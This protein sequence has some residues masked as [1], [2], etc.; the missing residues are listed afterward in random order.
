MKCFTGGGP[1]VALMAS[2]NVDCLPCTETDCVDINAISCTN[3]T[4][5]LQPDFSVSATSILQEAALDDMTGQRSVYRCAVSG[6][7]LGDAD[8]GVQTTSGPQCA[9]PYDGPLC[10]YCASG[11]SRPGFTGECNECSGSL[12]LAWAC[13]G[14]AIAIALVTQTLYWMSALHG[15]TK[16]HIVV[17]LGKIAVSLIQILTQLE[18]SLDV[19][20]PLEFRWFVDLLKVFSMDLLGFLNVGCL[21][22]YTYMSKFMFANLLAPI[23]L[24]A[25]GIV[26]QVRKDVASIGNRC[27]KMALAVMFLICTWIACLSSTLQTQIPATSHLDCCHPALTVMPLFQIHL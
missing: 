25:V 3:G 12:S 27:I 20:W 13:G 4:V 17:T 10:D 14:T 16:F 8:E 7:C 18:F 19:S 22:Q 24:L 11:Y 9:A 26:Y 1:W 6:A 21:A 2:S 5:T 15:T 23:M